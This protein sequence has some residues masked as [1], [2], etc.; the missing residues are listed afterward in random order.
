MPHIPLPVVVVAAL[1]LVLFVIKFL[2]GRRKPP[3]SGLGL[4]D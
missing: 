1:V 2:R 4:L 3:S